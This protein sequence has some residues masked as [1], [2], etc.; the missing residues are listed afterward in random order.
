MA[1]PTAPICWRLWRFPEA[2]A[3]P[4]ASASCYGSS[5]NVRVVPV[6]VAELELGDVERHVLPAHLVESADGAALEDR[7]EAFDGVGV[8]RA[9]NVFSP[10]SWLTTP[11]GYI[12]CMPRYAA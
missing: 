7:P 9:D 12:L 8:D 10:A 6:V 1:T 3:S 11:C 5:E 4:R 2:P